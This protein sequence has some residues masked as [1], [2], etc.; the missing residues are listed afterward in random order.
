MG[1]ALLKELGSVLSRQALSQNAKYKDL[2]KRSDDKLRKD[3]SVKMNAI[4]Q[5]KFGTDCPQNILDAKNAQMKIFNNLT[6][7]KPLRPTPE[8]VN[9]LINIRKELWKLSRQYM[10]F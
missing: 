3:L 6:G 8:L 4:Q 2:L 1:Q 9:S 5:I 10:V 7:K